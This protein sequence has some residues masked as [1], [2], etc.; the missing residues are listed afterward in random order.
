M[1]GDAAAPRLVLTTRSIYPLHGVGG[2]ERHLHDLVCY[3]AQ[4]G[5]HVCVVTRPPVSVELREVVSFPSGQVE[6]LFVPYRTFPGAGR[7]GTTILDRSTAYVLWGL[8]AGARAAALAEGGTVDAVYGHGASVLG[9]ARARRAGRSTTPLL[10]NPHGLEE[11]GGPGQPLLKHL[12]YAPLRAAVRYCAHAADLVIA[13]DHCLVPTISRHLHIAPDRLRVVP[14]AVDL[15]ACNEAQEVETGA[16]LRTGLALQAGTTLLLSTGRI[17]E[18]KGFHVLAAALSGLAR[19]LPDTRPWH[20]VLVGD[21]PFKPTLERTI[22]DL[23]LASHVFLAGHVPTPELHG[24]YRAADLFVHPTLYEGS[25]IVTL[26][27]MAH[28]LPVVASNAGGIPD[29]VIPSVTGWLVEPGDPAALARAVQ[30]AM[31]DPLR[32]KDMG[33]AGRARVEERFSWKASVSALLA[34]VRERAPEGRP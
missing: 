5:V 3:L 21:G 11:F 16:D 34:V 13:T 28:S 29:K 24:W 25:S 2:L 12:L 19:L 26:E 15:T 18:N 8:S 10:F 33:R 32:L 7:R 17:E 27:A 31:T 14:N 20:W 22:R 30:D 9:Y 4:A 6:W 23:G 1:T